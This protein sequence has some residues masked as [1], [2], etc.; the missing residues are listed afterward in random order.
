VIDPRDTTEISAGELGPL[1]PPGASIG[2]REV[3]ATPLDPLDQ[4]VLTWNRGDD[5]FG[6]EWG[7]VIWHPT[8]DGWRAVYGFT[9]APRK[10]VLGVALR[11]SDDVTGDGLPELLTLEE[12]GGS[13]SC[14]TWRV[15]SPSAAGADELLRS[16]TCD[17]ELRLTDG[18]L[19]RR[20]AVFAPGDPHCCP[21][22]YRTTTYEWD[23]SRFRRTSSST[24]PAGPS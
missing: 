2:M 10:G 12:Q 14:G 13:G 6:G 17:T 22:A 21:S 16:S 4:I 24:E 5:P 23:G 15:I 7:L 8:A 18:T 20:E 1:V 9:D 3:Q 11:G 19:Q